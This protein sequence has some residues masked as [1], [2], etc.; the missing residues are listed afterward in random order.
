MKRILAIGFMA[1]AMI[2]A[3]SSTFAQNAMKATI[4]FNFHLG[5]TTMPAGTYRVVR[6]PGSDIVSFQNEN[7]SRSGLAMKTWTEQSNDPAAKLI[8]AAYGRHYFLRKTV[9]NGVAACY[10]PSKLEKSIRSERASLESEKE[11]T[12]LLAAR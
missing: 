5:N 7:A 11:T 3:T 10:A 4:P 2:A 8:F 12:I 9:T 1:V 6:Q